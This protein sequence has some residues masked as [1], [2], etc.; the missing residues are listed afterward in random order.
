MALLF[1]WMHL[2]NRLQL[3][4]RL[5]FVPQDLFQLLGESCTTDIRS[6]HDLPEVDELFDAQIQA[7][8]KGLEGEV[9]I[10]NDFDIEVVPELEL[11]ALLS[12]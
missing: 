6:L 12:L 8:V 1:G 10:L 3:L 5:L 4:S 7:L 9:D 11:G 2:I